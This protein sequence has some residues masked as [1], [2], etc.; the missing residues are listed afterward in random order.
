MLSNVYGAI[1]ILEYA[2]RISFHWKNHIFHKQW[3]KTMFFHLKINYKL[4]VY[5]TEK[6]EISYRDAIYH[7]NRDDF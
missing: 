2:K 3:W 6:A 7:W 1:Y 5:F 4:K